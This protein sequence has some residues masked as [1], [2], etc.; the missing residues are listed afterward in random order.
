[1]NGNIL[2]V[3]DDPDMV[4]ILHSVLSEAGYT[5]RAA[6][7]GTEA[8]AQAR[9]NPPDLVLLDLILPDQNGF[10]ICEALRRDAATASVPIIMITGMPGEIARFAGFEAG[11]DAYLNK[12]FSI[13]GLVDL[14]RDLLLGKR[15]RPAAVA[16][17]VTLA[18]GTSIPLADWSEPARSTRRAFA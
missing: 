9:R 11:A 8:L 6:S 5:T 16:A 10:Y 14:V 13:D 17:G 4:E 2:I 15:R 1:M 12:P 3:D 18:S 7:N